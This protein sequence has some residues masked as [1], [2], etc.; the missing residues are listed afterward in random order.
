[1]RFNPKGDYKAEFEREVN[2]IIDQNIEDRQERI[3]AIG[4]LVDYYMLYIGEAPDPVQLE[5][6]ADYIL[7]EELNNTH[8]DKV[9][10]EEYPIFSNRQILRRRSGEVPLKVAEEVGTDG[11]DYKLPTRRKRSTRER[12]KI[13]KE[14]KSRNKE[15]RRRYAEYRRP[16]PVKTYYQNIQSQTTND[17]Y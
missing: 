17:I 1:M 15:R 5:R 16:G 8:P 11:R 3:K 13:D 12:W 10:R 2:E 4:A 14:T 6:L 9:A 7:R